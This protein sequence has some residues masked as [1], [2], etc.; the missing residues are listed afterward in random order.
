MN[1]FH[2]SFGAP[3]PKLVGRE[4]VLVDYRRVFGDAPGHPGQATVVVGPRGAGK[5]VLL[6]EMEGAAKANGWLVASETAVPGLLGRLIHHRI[7]KLLESVDVDAVQKRLKSLGWAGASAG[8]ETRER[9][10]ASEAFA[11]PDVR[12]VIE[13]VT[14]VLGEYGTGLLITVDEFHAAER[15]ELAELTAAIQHGFR[16]RRLIAFAAAGLPEAVDESLLD[17]EVLT[18]IR[19]AERVDLEQLTDE[20]VMSGIRDP[21]EDAGR[22]IT[23]GALDQAVEAT[24]GYAFMIQLVG[25][26][27]FDVHDRPTIGV[28]DAAL[29]IPR[30]QERLGRL[31]LASALKPVVKNRPRQFEYLMAMTIDDGPSS[32]ST[33]AKRM[34]LSVDHAGQFRGALIDEQLIHKTKQG[35]VDFSLPFLREYLRDHGTKLS[36]AVGSPERGRFS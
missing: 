21:I 33:I 34:G 2:P 18:F 32:T 14:D 3:P 6:S 1:P 23:A 5:T 4:S 35:F 12:G 29:G 17:D 10:P 11:T 28:D 13:I 27:M 15:N 36:S 20:D 24:A 16:E 31:V 22:E 7:P 19:R 30:A 26:H 25:Y 8:W 9:W